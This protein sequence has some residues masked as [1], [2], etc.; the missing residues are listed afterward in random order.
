MH[1]DRQKLILTGIG[2]I[3][4][5]SPVGQCRRRMLRGRS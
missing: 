3:D 1:L 2:V 4:E 5:D